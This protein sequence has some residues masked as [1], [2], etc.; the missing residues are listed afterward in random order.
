[1]EKARFFEEISEIL[2]IENDLTESTN[3]KE[4]AEYDS[5]AVL[6]II[7]FVDENFDKTLS[8]KQLMS[9]ESISQLIDLIGDDAII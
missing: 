9:V 7:A 5:L 6:S 3:L 8:G 2:D 4:M 1:M